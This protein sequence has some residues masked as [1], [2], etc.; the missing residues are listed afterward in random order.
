MGASAPVLT[1][2]KE[3]GKMGDIKPRSKSKKDSVV[4]KDAPAPSSQEVQVHFGNYKKIELALLNQI[5]SNLAELVRI[6]KKADKE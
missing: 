2:L 3:N 5:N 1:I 4:P 6:I